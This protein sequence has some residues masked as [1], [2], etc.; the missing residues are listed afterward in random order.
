MT[1]TF[2]GGPGQLTLCTNLTPVAGVVSVE[3]CT[4]AGSETT[5][6][7]LLASITVN[8]SS[9]PGT[10]G[11]F[12]PS[13]PGPA[14]QLAFTT[15]PVGGV[16]GAPLSTQPVVQVQDAYGNL[17]TTSTAIITLAAT[18]TG[19]ALSGCTNLYATGG[20]INVTG[21]VP[22]GVSWV[23]STNSWRRRGP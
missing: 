6:Y 15:P 18:G 8:G 3:N 4:F 13:L 16:A 11:N 19:A 22:S 23:R 5:S 1:L 9:A 17:V 12:S 14:T 21:C 20:V 7:Q 2:Q 10:S